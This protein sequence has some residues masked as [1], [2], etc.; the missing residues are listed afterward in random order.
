ME[1]KHH[2]Q[3]K[4]TVKTSLQLYATEHDTDGAAADSL[5]VLA[6]QTIQL[7]EDDL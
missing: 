6:T 2:G 4:A 7:D 1:S 5:L 3:M